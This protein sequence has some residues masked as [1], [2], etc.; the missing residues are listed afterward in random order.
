M[1]KDLCEFL[2]FCSWCPEH[3]NSIILCGINLKWPHANQII[4]LAPGS[5]R[6][7][8]PRFDYSRVVLKVH[9]VMSFIIAEAW[10]W[11]VL[12]GWHAKKK[13]LSH[14]VNSVHFSTSLSQ[15]SF[16]VFSLS[17]VKFLWKG[18][19]ISNFI[20][21]HFIKTVNMLLWHVSM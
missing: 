11:I 14:G 10:I 9:D 15:Q 3:K 4:L 13:T 17:S 19:L 7:N 21:R 18:H 16:N 1:W 6:L 8:I 5:C 20:S 12:W 2:P